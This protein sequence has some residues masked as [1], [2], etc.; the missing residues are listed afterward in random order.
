MKARKKTSK[1]QTVKKDNKQIVEIHI[2]IHQP[3]QFTHSPY[4][5]PAP[6]TNPNFPNYQQTPVYCSE[7]TR[8]VN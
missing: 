3:Y 7:S 6:N 5:H 8:Q 2:Y 4:T 1:K